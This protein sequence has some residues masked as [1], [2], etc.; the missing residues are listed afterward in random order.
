MDEKH[1]NHLILALEL[2]ILTALCRGADPPAQWERLTGQLNNYRWLDSDHK[3]VYDALRAIKSRDPKTRR[4]ELPAQATRMG[5]PDVDWKPYFEPDQKVAS[6]LQ[7]L[8]RR[9]KAP[10]PGSS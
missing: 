6:D 5:F 1:P 10:R 2:R 3:V 4:D 7:D 8:I 9:L